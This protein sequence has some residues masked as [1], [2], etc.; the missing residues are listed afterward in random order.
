[1]H[2]SPRPG[3]PLS[4]CGLSLSASYLFKSSHLISIG[5]RRVLPRTRTPEDP[6]ETVPTLRSFLSQTSIVMFP[7]PRRIPQSPST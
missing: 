5:F 7:L 1:M 6:M 3:N 2:D 4:P